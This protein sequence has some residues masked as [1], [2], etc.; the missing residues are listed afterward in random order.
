[1]DELIKDESRPDDSGRA[2][3]ALEELVKAGSTLTDKALLIWIL[4]GH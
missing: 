4:L 3:L 2:S 1:L